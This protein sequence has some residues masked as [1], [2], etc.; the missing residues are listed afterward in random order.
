MTMPLSAAAVPVPRR[1]SSRLLV[2]TAYVAFFFGA[3]PGL[4]WVLGGRMDVLLHLPVVPGETGRGFG[5]V[6]AAAGT[7]WMG[8]SMGSL[9]RRGRGLP[10]SHLPPTRLVARGPYALM[11]H[12]IYVGYAAAFGGA[13]LAVGSLG[14]GI[15]AT[16]LLLSGSTIYALGLEEPRLVRRYG[17]SYREYI[18][19]T[20][21][22][23]LPR[24][25]M[26]AP[27][28][29]WV[30]ARPSLEAL[31]NR[32]VLFRVGPT[33]WVT[34]GAFAGLGT[35]LGL[36]T[37]HLLLRSAL[38]LR[39][40]AIY[41]LGIALW[42]LFGARL[43]ALL[44][45]PR[46]LV[47]HPSE[48]FRR[49]GFV[50]WGG[51]LGMFTFPFLFARLV[52][53]D[54]WWLLDRTFVSAL[55]CSS[56]GRVGCLS[57]GCCYGRPSAMGICWHHPDAKVNRERG[58]GGPVARIPTQLLSAVCTAS[59]LP[60]VAVTAAVSRP[61]VAT[62]IGSLLY[63]VA[64]FGVECLRD[65]ARYGAWGMTRGQVASTIGAAISIGLLLVVPHP[66]HAGTVRLASSPE[67]GA[68]AW[69]FVATATAVVF[70][71][72]SIHWKRVG[73]W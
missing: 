45:Q 17:P 13:G 34:Y 66:E 22:L 50:S 25:L 61:G 43:V 33:V 14:R 10:I 59:I 44:Y 31:A 27:S 40:D 70:L 63:C 72:C 19:R 7:F 11:R 42:M 9:S 58:P 26:R 8:W 29:V 23:P 60:V 71:V 56:I 20:P 35:G 21:V 48:A 73:R 53:G 68:A 46:L 37:C 5:M 18:E 16:A 69:L 67:D 30:W 65:E 3:L 4:L 24:W 6:L 62:M 47:A 28:R 57:Y 32:V 54:A 51:Y 49:V 1:A 12:P 52:G 38:P 55:V 15:G 39:L 41:V 2:V 36:I 64:R